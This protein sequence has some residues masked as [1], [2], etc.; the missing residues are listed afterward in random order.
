VDRSGH[1]FERLGVGQN[2]WKSAVRIPGTHSTD[3]TD[4]NA[5]KPAIAQ[6]VFVNCSL[7]F[8]ARAHIEPATPAAMKTAVQSQT[9]TEVHRREL[10]LVTAH[11]VNWRHQ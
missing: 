2:F 1:T 11:V 8:R 3:A 9:V 6:M 10:T 5:H 7:P 4:A